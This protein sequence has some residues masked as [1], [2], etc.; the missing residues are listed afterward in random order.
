M[1]SG[2]HI[3]RPIENAI[4]EAF[5]NQHHLIAI[6]LDMEK[7]YDMLSKDRIIKIFSTYQVGRNM[8]KFAENF[9]KN[10]NTRTCKWPSIRKI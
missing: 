1:D 2:N 9:L 5:I 7:A 4:C 6:A 10:I 3:Q 8:L